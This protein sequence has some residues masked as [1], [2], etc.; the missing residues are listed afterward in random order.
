MVI[1]YKVCYRAFV[2]PVYRFGYD[3]ADVWVCLQLVYPKLNACRQMHD[4]RLGCLSL[5]PCMTS[6]GLICLK[7]AG[8]KWAYVFVHCFFFYLKKCL[9][10]KAVSSAM[11][12]ISM[13]LGYGLCSVDAV[14]PVRLLSHT[15]AV[16]MLHAYAITF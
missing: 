2:L 4:Q 6:L 3:S 9:H 1:L 11:S 13:S 8:I 10:V 7:T 16:S 14:L 5:L 12:A 15:Q